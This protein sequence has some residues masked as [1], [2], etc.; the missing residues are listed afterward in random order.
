METIS[1]VNKYRLV[2]IHENFYLCPTLKNLGEALIDY[3]KRDGKLFKRLW[4]KEEA[5]I[6]SVVKVLMRNIL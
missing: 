4:I 3:A 6:I 2:I 5:S 1:R